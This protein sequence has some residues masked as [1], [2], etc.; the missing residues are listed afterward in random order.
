MRKYARQYIDDIFVDFGEQ[1]SIHLILINIDTHQYFFSI[2]SIYFNIFHF[3]FNIFQY[4][5]NI[6]QYFFNIFQYFTIHQY[7]LHNRQEKN[8]ISLIHLQEGRLIKCRK[9]NV[10]SFKTYYCLFYNFFALVFKYIS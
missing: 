2:F 7:I 10:Q 6:F 5:F 4:F 3:F 8:N 1:P 9:K